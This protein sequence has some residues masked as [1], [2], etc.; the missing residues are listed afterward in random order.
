MPL[1]FTVEYLLSRLNPYGKPYVQQGSQVFNNA[2]I[3]PA[4]VVNNQYALGANRYALIAYKLTFSNAIVP[5]AL[6]MSFTISGVQ[7][8]NDVLRASILRDPLDMFAVLQSQD[9]NL[10]ITN[11]SAL[12]QN[13]EATLHFLTVLNKDDWA[14]VQNALRRMGW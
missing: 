2:G 7:I 8:Y 13:F 1:P 5:A 12:A 4:A 11:V 3:A 14:A 10:A 9:V 6:S